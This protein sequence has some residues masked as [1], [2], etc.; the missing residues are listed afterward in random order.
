MKTILFV[1]F[2]LPSVALGQSQ[3]LSA[4]QQGVGSAVLATTAINTACDADPTTVAT[5]SLTCAAFEL[6]MAGFTKAWLLFKYTRS[7]ATEIQIFQDG[8]L[9]KNNDK[10]ADLPWGIFQRPEAAGSGDVELFNEVGRK[11]ISAAST[12]F[13]V[14]YDIN[15]PFVRWRITSTGG[16]A[17]DTIAVFLVRRGP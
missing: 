7:T 12:S 14:E 4:S 10:T 16:A 6:K 9:D 15:S 13:I 1:L 8:A 11:P 5:A 3:S 17:G 2:L